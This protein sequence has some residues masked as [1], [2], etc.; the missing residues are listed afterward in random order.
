MAKLLPFR[1]KIPPFSQ[2][3]TD[4]LS[5]E[6]SDASTDAADG[7]LMPDDRGEEGVLEV[8]MVWC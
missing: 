3:L 4:E 2:T 7:V 6:L 8:V 1:S 5:E